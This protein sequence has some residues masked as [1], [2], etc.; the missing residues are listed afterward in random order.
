MFRSNR[1]EFV[2]VLCC[3]NSQSAILKWTKCRFHYIN[4]DCHFCWLS[5]LSER[6]VT[7]FG[8]D[9]YPLEGLIMKLYWKL[10]CFLTQETHE[11]LLEFCTFSVILNV[12]SLIFDLLWQWLALS[13]WLFIVTNPF[14]QYHGVLHNYY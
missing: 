1:R 3:R 6:T 4:T 8:G 9:V 11:E 13:I 14:N 2:T 5:V 12:G 7:S 10:I